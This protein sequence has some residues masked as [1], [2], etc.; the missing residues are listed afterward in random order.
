ML[1]EL[2]LGKVQN[3]DFDKFKLL[4]NN[5]FQ[6]QAAMKEKHLRGNQAPFMNKSILKVTLARSRLL[7]KFR[8]EITLLNQLAHKRHH[9]F[10]VNLSKKTKWNLYN[11]LNVN[12]FTNNK[13][14]WKRVKPGL[15]KNTLEDEKYSI[16]DTR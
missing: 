15:T 9:N 6:S 5:L 13:P 1:I 2:S 7:N 10:S 3:E 4:V 11:T 12:K 8:K 16:L 14:F